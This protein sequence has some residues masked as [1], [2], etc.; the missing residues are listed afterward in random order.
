MVHPL[1]GLL[2]FVWL[3]ALLFLVVKLYDSMVIA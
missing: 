3:L 1:A 2:A